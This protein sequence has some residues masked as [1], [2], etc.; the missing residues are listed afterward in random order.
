MALRKSRFGHFYGCPNF[1]DCDMLVGCHPGTTEPL[2]H[3]ADRETR[4]WRIRAHDAFDRL[5]KGPGSRM[6]RPRAYRQLQRIMGLPEDK[7]HIGM[8]DK[9]QCQCLIEKLHQT[10]P[11]TKEPRHEQIR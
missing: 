5:W 1:P 2:G 7:A 10:F 4:S 6:S 9:E 3:P 8:F 11:H